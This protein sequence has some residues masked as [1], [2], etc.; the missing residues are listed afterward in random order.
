MRTMLILTGCVALAGVTGGCASGS[1]PSRAASEP[2]PTR[3]V[4]ATASQA[5]AMAR[6]YVSQLGEATAIVG[7]LTSA[8]RARE[9]I[10]ALQESLGRLSGFTGELR[11][12]DGLPLGAREA[13]ADA[14]AAFE[15]AVARAMAR[16]EV[17]EVAGSVLTRAQLLRP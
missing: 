7:R 2:A 6:G 12:V 3:A 13:I 11:S 9:Q 16:A 5:E 8:Q 14:N 4:S 17:A 10:G 1:A 15:A